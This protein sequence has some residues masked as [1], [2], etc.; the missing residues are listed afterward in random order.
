MAATLPNLKHLPCPAGSACT[1][2]KCLFGHDD[3]PDGQS[4]STGAADQARNTPPPP[5]SV[6]KKRS[7]QSPVTVDEPIPKRTKSMASLSSRATTPQAPEPPETRMLGAPAGV[8]AAFTAPVRKPEQSVQQTKTV[9]TTAASQSIVASSSQLKPPG[10]SVRKPP[11]VVNASAASSLTSRQKP[12]SSRPPTASSSAPVKAQGKPTPSAVSVTKQLSKQPPLPLK[13]PPRPQKGGLLT[14]KTVGSDP[15]GFAGRLKVIQML[16]AELIRLDGLLRDTHSGRI[17]LFLSQEEADTMAIE[18][19]GLIAAGPSNVYRNVVGARLSGF[20]KMTLGNWLKERELIKRPPKPKDESGNQPKI[21]DTGLTPEQEIFVA[22]HLETPIHDLAQH[23]YVP[24]PPSAADISKASAAMAMSQGWE[25]CDRCEQRF[26]VFPD[27]RLEDGS[28]TSGGSCTYHPGRLY[29]TS[30]VSDAGKT[31][32]RGERK[33]R[34]CNQA[35][36]DSAGCT[37]GDCHVFKVTDAARLSN[38]LPFTTT[39]SN[40]SPATDS[41]AVCFDC[42]MCYTVNGIELVRLTATAWPSGDIVLD[43]LVQPQGAI[44]DLNSR[45]SGVFPQDLIN[46]QLWDGFQD[47]VPAPEPGATTVVRSSQLKI[48]N[49]PAAARDLFFALLTPDTL[50][51]GHG[52]ENDL[53]ATRVIHPKLIDTVLLYPTR[54]GLPSRMGLKVLAS[55]HLNRKI[56]VDDGSGQGHDSAEDARAAGELVRVKVKEKWNSMQAKGWRLQNDKFVAP[57][58]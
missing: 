45:Y 39:P 50:L 54:G 10:A 55:T 15:I 47:P 12:P 24:T 5:T 38:V 37:T 14:P 16:H 53:N 31:R 33:Y 3:R 28:H 35:I 6:S 13:A 7:F 11:L 46:A 26:Q 52:L 29:W 2:F 9:A 58:S 17:E 36:G 32:A 4:P 8:V 56:Q 44:L 27:R 51:I 34:C 22:G 23:G 18:I 49:S 43:V 40:D 25:K 1:A 48:V 20:K 42:E 57:G 41:K 19:E 30:P 21:I